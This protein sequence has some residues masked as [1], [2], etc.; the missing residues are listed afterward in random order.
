[1]KSK[2]ERAAY[3]RE[4]Y[5]ANIEKCREERLIAYHKN[6]HKYLE[7]KKINNANRYVP[8]PRVAK[9]VAPIVKSEIKIEKVKRNFTMTEIMTTLR[10]DM[11][12]EL[13]KKSIKQWNIID[14][15]KFNEI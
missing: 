8:K 15:K 2:Q 7:R 5:A 4:W 14:W 13:W 3:Q 6:K 10:K 12:H 11:K 1:M 9:I